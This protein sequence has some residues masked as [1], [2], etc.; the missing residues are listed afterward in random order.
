MGDN[1]R[2]RGFDFLDWYVMCR[3]CGETSSFI[4]TLWESSLVVVFVSRSFGVMWILPKSIHALLFGWWNWLGKHSSD[5]WNLVPLSLMWCIWRECNW[6]TFENMD[7]LDNQLIASFS[8]SLFDWS[9]AWRL[10]SSESL[11]MF[12][13]SLLFCN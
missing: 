4:A 13:S 9:R 1:L 11:P 3:Y 12:I 6:W 7:S 2:S 5:I 10:T 8:G